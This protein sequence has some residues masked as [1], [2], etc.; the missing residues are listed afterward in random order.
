MKW[1]VVLSDIDI[2]SAELKA[3]QKV[4]KSRWLSMGAV[5]SE[6]EKSFAGFIGVKHALAVSNGTAALHLAHL[7]AGVK[8]GE[9]VLVPSLTFVATVNSIL[10]C[11]AKPVFVDVCGTDNLNL[12]PADLE[13]KFTEKTK[14]VLVVHYAGYP[15]QMPKIKE[16][17]SRAQTK[18][19]RKIALIE[20]AAHAPG[21]ELAG[22]KCGA[23]GDLGCFS[24]FANKNLVT[25][26]GGMITTDSD[27]LAEKLRLMRSHGMTTIS[28]QRQ[29]GHAHTYDVVQLGYNF[30]LTEIEAALGLEQLKKLKSSNLKRKRLVEL[31]RKNLGQIEELTV[32]FQGF[33]GKSSYHIF[34][35]I[36][37][38]AVDR[39]RF[40]EITKKKGI[41]TSIHYPP[42]HLFSYYQHR[43][44]NVRL[45]QTEL[46]G[47]RE[48]TLPL[49]PRMKPAD[50]ILVCRAVE[51][52]LRQ[53]K[54]AH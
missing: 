49:H 7:A 27:D 20:D 34:P 22:K 4:L 1:K 33:Q 46:V 26:E 43:F 13:R 15:A 30:R 5:S 16:A 32:P 23:W 38:E 21:A 47:A 6:F 36:L 40:I 45:P 11:G 31:Y 14:A 41:Q 10:Y 19:N 53:A 52:A 17:I 18:F 50:V 44:S 51:K 28:W 25:G 54:H 29:Q 3:V 37:S 48:V 35:V 8:P 39:S 42:V 9:E 24:F 2:S 12:S